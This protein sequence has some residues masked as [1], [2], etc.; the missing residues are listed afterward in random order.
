MSIFVKVSNF[1]NMDS[2]CSFHHESV[3][4][5]DQTEENHKRF[6]NEVSDEK[7]GN[8]VLSTIQPQP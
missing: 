4:G 8:L 7:N 2:C 1:W 3:E 5:S 6:M